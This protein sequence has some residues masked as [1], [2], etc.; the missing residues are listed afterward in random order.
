[1][2]EPFTPE[3]RAVVVDAQAQARRLRHGRI[4]T[5]HLLLAATATDGR[6]ARI[7]AAHGI[8]ADTVE[9]DIA[10]LA[11]APPHERDRDALAALGIDLD[12]VRRTVDARFGSGALARAASPEPR[13]RWF[14]RRRHDRHRPPTGH[15][16]FDAGAKKALELSLREALR[17]GHR[18]IGTEHVALGL[19]RGGDGLAS[20]ALV[21]RGATIA[22]LRAEI[23]AALRVA[24]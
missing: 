14:R 3:A 15:I 20:A 10:D 11:G 21:R 18:S 13:R 2:F 19:L 8:T 17:L 22:G 9:A 16:P 12:D 24:V 4:G 7:L 23:E 6:V 5:E 1:M